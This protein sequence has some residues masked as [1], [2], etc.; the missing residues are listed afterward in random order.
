[1]ARA[2]LILGK[3]DSSQVK[4]KTI[5]SRLH[6]SLVAV[7]INEVDRSGKRKKKSIETHFPQI[8]LPQATNHL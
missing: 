4:E 8:N 2:K 1:V 7:T 6:E 5:D 3:M